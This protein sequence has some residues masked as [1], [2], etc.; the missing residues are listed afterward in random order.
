MRVFLIGFG[1]RK[2]EKWKRCKTIPF[3]AQGISHD[4]V[5]T[6]VIELITHYA[7]FSTF[8]EYGYKYV[9][10]GNVYKDKTFSQNQHNSEAELTMNL[11]NTWM[12]MRGF[13]LYMYTLPNSY[14]YN[15]KASF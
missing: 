14:V 6:N 2:L 15:I 13:F 4:T 10:A 1:E 12:S 5:T 7:Y 11:C 9:A 3:S 8:D